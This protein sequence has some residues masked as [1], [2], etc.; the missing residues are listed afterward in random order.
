MKHRTSTKHLLRFRH[1]SR[2]AYAAFA[3]IGRYVTIGCLRKCVA[4]SSLSKQEVTGA[5]GHAGCAAEN[6][7]TGRVEK[8]TTP[9]SLS[10]DDSLL[11]ALIHSEINLQSLFRPA[12]SGSCPKQN[13]EIKNLI[14][15][16]NPNTDYR[17]QRQAKPALFFR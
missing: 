10:G 16:G 5:T 9:G 15:K 6:A 8:E 7:W 12:E 17:K 14:N 2:K 1:W 11:C 3:S 4:D 13:K